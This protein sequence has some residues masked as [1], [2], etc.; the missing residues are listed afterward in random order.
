MGIKVILEVYENEQK[1]QNVYDLWFSDNQFRDASG[2][3]GGILIG[4]FGTF[5]LV[6]K[7]QLGNAYVHTVNK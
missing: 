3:A 1:V 5:F 4:G 6:P 2:I 7:L